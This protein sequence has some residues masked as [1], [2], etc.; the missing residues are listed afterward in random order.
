MQQ[1]SIEKI[2]QLARQFAGLK[3]E[4]HYHLLTP[5]CRFNSRKAY[6]FVLENTSEDTY[7]VCYTENPAMDLGKRLLPLLHGEDMLASYTGAS[8]ISESTKRI[9][10]KAEQL[11]AAG[12]FWHHHV[13]F[14][15]CKYNH[16][17]EKWNIVFED[18][19][20]GELV[21]SVS[22]VNSKDEQ[23]EIERLYYLQKTIV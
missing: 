11:N 9:I 6:A 23:K 2:E 20:T 14:P 7:Y 15:H 18:Q 22:D 13:L 1:V 16:H 21:E 12:K 4:W 19:E 3:R 10:K 17:K 8:V 5:T